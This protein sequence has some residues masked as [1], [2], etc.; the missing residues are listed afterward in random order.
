MTITLAPRA[1]VGEPVGA[2]IGSHP[3]PVVV[4]ATR[5]KAEGDLSPSWILVDDV[6]HGVFDLLT[7]LLDALDSGAT[8][9]TQRLCKTADCLPGACTWRHG[10]CGAVAR[11]GS[12][13]ASCLTLLN[14][15]GDRGPEPNVS[16]P[17]LRVLTAPMRLFRR[18]WS[19]LAQ[20]IPQLRV[21]E[22]C[23]AS[24]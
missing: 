16:R 14:H 5:G 23:G 13:H 17:G 6:V 1:D 18:Y 7:G 11:A 4:R 12:F 9:K 15:C 20:E 3:D 2:T 8:A 24:N 22:F 21:G 10:G 19:I